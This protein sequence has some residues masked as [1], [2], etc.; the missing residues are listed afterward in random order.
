M[1]KGFGTNE[2]LIRLVIM[3]FYV[4]IVSHSAAHG[5]DFTWSLQ[6]CID[7]AL[8]NNIQIKRSNLDSLSAVSTLNQSRAQ[9][10]PSLS[11]SAS[12]QLSPPS[13]SL[14]GLGEGTSQS[15]RYSLSANW[16]T[17]SG[18]SILTGIEKS[19]AEVN[20]SSLYSKQSENGVIIAVAQAYIDVLFALETVHNAQ[21]ALQSSQMQ[22][23]RT[24]NLREAGSASAVDVTG[25]RAQLA[26][27]RY[28][29]V[30]ARNN[31]S[32]KE[33]VLRQLLEVSDKEPFNVVSPIDDTLTLRELPTREAFISAVL[34]SMPDLTIA[35]LGVD[36][37]KL[38]LRQSQ[39]GYLPT[40]SLS[41]GVSISQD[42]GSGTYNMTDNITGSSER[43]ST[44]VGAQLS[45]PLLDRRRNRTAVE[46][47]R[48][49]IDKAELELESAR[50]KLEQ[51]A[52][53]VY[54]NAISARARLE[55]AQERL[56]AAGASHD[57]ANEQYN[58]GIIHPSELLVQKNA[59]SAA[60]SEYM[61]AKYSALLY[62]GLM[63]IYRGHTSDILNME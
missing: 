14:S 34:D 20:R 18:T 43:V 31:L 45:I 4:S 16:T 42:I 49:G 50:R 23:E 39:S 11:G 13:N 8:Q 55:A 47:A 54:Q 53:T 57:L 26:N 35:H 25:M 12:Y 21:R 28:Q 61:Q 33:L 29:L 63:N 19:E 48:I 37:A 22:Y 56:A 46:Q 15:M 10:L 36:I 5:Q 1:F 30:I 24:V 3:T 59:F 27:D 32:G 17:F 2:R 40:L 62:T 60:E 9:I 51:T 38:Q 7:Y 52:Q 58:L 44:S 41:A 6:Q